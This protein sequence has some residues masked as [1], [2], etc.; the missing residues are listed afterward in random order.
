MEKEPFHYHIS[1]EAFDE[2]SRMIQEDADE[3]YSLR[4]TTGVVIGF[5]TT[6]A[7]LYQHLH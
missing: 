1:K 7:W 2:A 3:L 6:L 4:L 5:L